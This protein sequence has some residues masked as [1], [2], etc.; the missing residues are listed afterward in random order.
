[1]FSLVFNEISINRTLLFDIKKVC[2]MRPKTKVDY[3]KRVDAAEMLIF[4]TSVR[5]QMSEI[6][7]LTVEIR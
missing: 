2:E 4:L 7:K 5:F 3:R 6:R 1:M